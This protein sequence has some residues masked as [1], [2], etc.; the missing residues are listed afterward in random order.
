MNSCYL[1]DR[2]VKGQIEKVNQGYREKARMARRWIDESLGDA[3]THC[4]GGSA[5][6]YYYLTLDGIETGEGSPFFRFLARTTGDATV[7]GPP[8]AKKPRV[9]HIP[10]EY[11]V[12]PKGELVGRGKTQLRLSYGFEEPGRIRKALELMREAVAFARAGRASLL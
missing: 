2:H 3:L 6:F 7:D 4:S 9:V 5:G 1:L 10:G 12:H 8:G 11:C